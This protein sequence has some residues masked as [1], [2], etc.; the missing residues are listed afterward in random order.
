MR[1]QRI[2]IIGAGIAGL[3]LAHQLQQRHTVTVFEKA[4]GVGGRMSTRFAE[5]YY[6]DH[7]AL[8]F[9]ARHKKFKAF[10]APLLEQ[11]VVAVWQPR[12]ITLEQNK[13]PYK[14]PWFEPHYVATPQMNS[15]CKYLSKGLNVQVNTQVAPL[16]QRTEQG[17]ALE[18]TQGNALGAFDWVISTAPAPQNL[19]LFPETF[20]DYATLKTIVMTGCYTL[21]LAFADPLPFSWDVAKVKNS[22]LQWIIKNNSK[23]L[24]D[25]ALQTLV[26]HSTAEWAEA[27]IDEDVPAMQAILLKELDAVL[28]YPCAATATMI[29][30]HRWRY[31][32]VAVRSPKKFFLDATQQLAACGDGLIGGRIEAAFMSA[33]LLG[34]ELQMQYL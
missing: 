29:T 7:G 15:L 34:E 18:D 22:P 14:R 8:F 16:T 6:F 2:A 3:T 32:D 12:A 26:V 25:K 33:T 1:H 20:S 5:P 27:H 21:M 24:R 11:G 13:N 23:P 9:T 28:G 10:L 17:W 4:R 19:Q 30:T 31:A